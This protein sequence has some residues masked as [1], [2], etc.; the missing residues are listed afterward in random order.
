MPSNFSNAKS[1]KVQ[2]LVDAFCAARLRISSTSRIST[3]KLHHAF[4]AW[5]FSPPISKRLLST[6][7][8]RW[9]FTHSGIKSGVFWIDGKSTRGFEG[10][11]YTL[12]RRAPLNGPLKV[13]YDILQQSIERNASDLLFV[14]RMR[15]VCDLMLTTDINAWSK[16]T[17]ILELSDYLKKYHE[18]S[19]VL[20]LIND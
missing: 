15:G 17:A 4:T 7:I 9:A 10:V 20:A 19:T 6:C 13:A 1:L 5:P 12:S 8:C 11:D 3:A 16:R 18:L 2:L 14:E